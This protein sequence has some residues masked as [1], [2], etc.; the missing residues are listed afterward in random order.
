MKLCQEHRFPDG[1][2]HFQMA[3]NQ[4]SMILSLIHISTK[5]HFTKSLFTFHVATADNKYQTAVYLTICV[6]A[7]SYTHLDVYKRQL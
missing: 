3:G 6:K 4:S 7:V 1:L 2:K 5:T